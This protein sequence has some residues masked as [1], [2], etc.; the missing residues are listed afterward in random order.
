MV[1]THLK[2]RETR[3]DGEARLKWKL[4]LVKSLYRK[5]YKRE[6][7][8]RLFLFTDWMMHLPEELSERFRNEVAFYE[9]EN[10]MPYVSSVEKIGIKKG[11]QQGRQ[12]GILLGI[13]EMLLEALQERFG[14]IHPSLAEAIQAIDSPVVLKGLH[15]QVF[16]VKNTEEF[17]EIL[18][19][20]K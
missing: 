7:V 4:S 9:E 15:R 13:R 19:S 14:V 8:I 2:T 6:D 12:E 16:R 1:L 5:G 10:K 17:R 3:R 20:L 18:D 11:I